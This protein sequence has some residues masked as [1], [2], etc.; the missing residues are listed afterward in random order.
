MSAS[1]P[2]VWIPRTEAA[3]SKDPEVRPFAASLLSRWDGRSVGDHSAPPDSRGND[4]LTAREREV[5]ALI[6][7]GHSNKR[8]ARMLEISPET[9]KS[10]VTSI[11]LKLA[12]NTRTEAVFR[13]VSLEL[14]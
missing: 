9:V 6:S 13:A 3:D 11:F 10:H 8:V 7:Q 4:R 14:L 12:V 5:L 2:A 1:K